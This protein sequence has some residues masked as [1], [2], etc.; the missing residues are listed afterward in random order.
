MAVNSTM[1]FLE[2]LVVGAMTAVILTVFGLVMVGLFRRTRIH[3]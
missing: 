3:H 1:E 2:L